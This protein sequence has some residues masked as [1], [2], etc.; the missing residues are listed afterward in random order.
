MLTAA[1]LAAIMWCEIRGKPNPDRIIGE[2]GK[3]VGRFQITQPYL[4]DAN[5]FMGTHLTILDMC[6]PEIAEAVMAAYLAHYVPLAEKKAG[7][8]LADWEVALIHH[9]GPNG[10]KHGADDHYAIEFN[11]YMATRQGE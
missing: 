9:H 7:R 4:D 6:N 3:S 8:E 10:W 5:R 11:N 1:F 2:D